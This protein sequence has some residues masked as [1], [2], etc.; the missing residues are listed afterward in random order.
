MAVFTDNPSLIPS[1]IADGAHEIV[2]K[3]GRYF[4]DAPIKISGAA[5]VT[6][7]ADGVVRLIGGKPL[8]GA[9]P[10]SGDTAA[11]F[12]CAHGKVM[13]VNLSENGVTQ[14]GD[15]VSRGFARPVS[16]SH[17][18]IFADGK[19][20]KLSQ[21]PA[22]GYLKIS[23]FETPESDE[24]WGAVN[25]KLSDGFYYK[26]ER[27]K[28]WLFSSDLIVHGYWAYDWANSYESVELLDA[29]R[30]FV[31]NR[32]PYGNY[33]FHIG[34][35][36]C[37]LNI[38]E[39]VCSP[40]DYYID[41]AG[42]MLYFIPF[43]DAARNE[44]VISQC[45]E[46]AFVLENCINTTLS[47]ITVEAFRGDAITV[48]GGAGNSVISCHIKNIGNRGVVVN[49]CKDARIEGCDIHDCGD[50][51]IEATGGNRRTLESS[52]IL[53]YNNHI[54]HIAKWTRCYQTAANITGVGITVSH[55]L[56]HDL[57]HTAV[58]YWGNDMQIT[59]NE[60]YSAV[61]ETGDAGAVYSGRD[62]TCRGN[63]VSGN[64]IHHLGG[65]GMGTMGIYNDDC[66]SGTVME[67]NFFFECSRAIFLGGGRDFIARRNICKDC[68]PCVSIDGRG[69]SDHGMWRSMV[70]TTLRERFYNIAG[71]VGQNET[72]QNKTEL[73]GVDSPYIDRYPKLAEI[74]AYYEN[75]EDIP[76]IPVSALIRDNVFCS[77][78]EIEY[79]WDC[80]GGEFDVGNNYSVKPDAFVSAD[81]GNLTLRGDSKPV[82]D[83]MAVR[84]IFEIGLAESERATHPAAVYAKLSR[85]GD[86][87]NLTLHNRRADLAVGEYVF[88]SDNGDAAGFGAVSFTLS[89][90][91]SKMYSLAIPDGAE[92]VTVRSTLP[93]ARPACL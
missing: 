78:R 64:Y 92:K 75:G 84:D 24:G 51:G 43:E 12:G 62:Y 85:D 46:P 88:Y 41:R 11:R 26:D 4:I 20:L 7:K 15:F 72:A 80:D 61:L 47:G 59:D 42:G 13:T 10:V 29:E 56:M 58:L 36:F 63:V 2:I 48:S 68:Y 52:E 69:K 71:Y 67:D 30:G 73:T 38:L 27:P 77:K 16:P 49:Y 65:V 31:K 34:Q 3:P 35:R 1:L 70:D 57:P 8:S 32:P 82:A 22:N 76:H 44:L 37:F 53:I 79:D 91:E 74:D 6:V 55:N 93:G 14:T 50:G 28:S 18:E 60:I 86:M 39:E 87:L 17:S 45:A 90:G 19:P 54:H 66:L 9:R 21:Y 23:G 83:G 25:G 33:Q 40:G 81:F 89:G 5:D